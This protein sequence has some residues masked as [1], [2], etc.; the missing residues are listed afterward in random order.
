[1][2]RWAQIV[3]CPG[4]HT[5]SFVKEVSSEAN[6]RM[7]RRSPEVADGFSYMV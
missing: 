4:K 3:S 2:S 7:D 5:T 1:M 6:A